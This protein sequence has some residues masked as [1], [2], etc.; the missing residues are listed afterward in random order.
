MIVSRGG[1]TCT[2]IKA[3]EQIVNAH[4]KQQIKNKAVRTD[5]TP[6]AEALRR[7]SSEDLEGQVEVSR[8]IKVML[9]PQCVE[10]CQKVGIATNGSRQDLR[11]RLAEYYNI[12]LDAATA[13]KKQGTGAKHAAEWQSTAVPVTPIPFTDSQ[14]NLE[15][16]AK[17]LPSFPDKMPSPGE[18][19]NFYFTDEMIDLGVTCSNVYPSYLKSCLV[20]PPW[21]REGLPWPPKWTSNPVTFNHDTFRQQ[22]M[23]MYMLG[24]KQKRRCRYVWTRQ[25]SCRAVVKD[26]DQ[27]YHL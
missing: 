16:L 25:L 18:A 9:K 7:I 10:H 27:T 12:D 6:P 20:R 22:L 4:K 15:S 5:L 13:L 26:H 1:R 8:V 2:R 14:F 3:R 21:T 23:V 17:F 19:W 24:L 11:D